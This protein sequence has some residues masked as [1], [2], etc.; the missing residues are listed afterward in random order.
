MGIRVSKEKLE[1]LKKAVH[2][3]AYALYSEFVRRTALLEAIHI[4]EK[5]VKGEKCYD[6]K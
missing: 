1:K 5:S 2:L 3:E 6:N 4:I